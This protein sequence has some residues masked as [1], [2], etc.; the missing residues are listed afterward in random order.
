MLSA[1]FFS[2]H[3][4]KIEIIKRNNKMLSQ[5]K[6]DDLYRTLFKMAADS[7]VLIDPKTGE[8]IDFNDSAH[9]NLGY[10]RDE[11]ERIRIKDLD[12]YEP[13]DLFF[14]GKRVETQ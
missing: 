5:D 4:L 12:V 3:T 9:K 6:S 13:P 1:D 10:S 2:T 8:I 11:F 14:K 7:I